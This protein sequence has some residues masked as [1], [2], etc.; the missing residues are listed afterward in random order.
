MT[1]AIVG[2]GLGGIAAAVK[3]QQAGFP[4]FTVF[5]QSAGPG[6]TWWDNTYPGAEVD[7]HSH[8]Y[9]YSFR[10]HDWT[11]THAG[12][13]ELQRYIE[14]TIDC[15]GVGDRLRLGARVEQVTWDDEREHWWVRLA[16]G[17]EL[18]YD[19]VISAVGLLNHPRLPDWPGLDTFA[20]P[21][22]HTA[23]WE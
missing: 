21:H 19:M 3:L 22:F 17:E 6:G 12:Q 7:I 23:R 13:A 1:V 14:E 2:A 16:A 8:L 4:R 9:S 18:A 15:F 20:G 10:A 5:E 11:R